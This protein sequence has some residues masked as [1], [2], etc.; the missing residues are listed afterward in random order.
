MA[1]TVTITLT[2]AGM[3]T[4]PFDLYSDADGYVTPFE[5]GVLKA[6][7]VAGYTSILVPDAATTIRVV[8]V[9]VC[10][11]FV[12]LPIEVVTPTTTT[13]STSSTTTTTTTVAPLATIFVEAD[14]KEADPNQGYLQFYASVTSGTT[15]DILLFTGTYERFTNSNCTS[16]LGNCFFTT[17]ALSIAG[18]VVQSGPLCDYV[19][20]GAASVKLI[21]LNV[22][23]VGISS[24]DQTITVSGNP[25]RIT[26]FGDC[27]SGI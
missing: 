2:T 5:T 15:S 1:Q 24:N 26:G 13:T 3:D 16:S 20:V 10:T 22:N 7:L 25:Y 4:G 11:N 6:F 17:E 14:T 21:S 12:D 27:V 18:T 23:G 8:S 19:G 9:G